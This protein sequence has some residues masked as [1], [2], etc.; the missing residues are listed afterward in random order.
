MTFEK[1]KIQTLSIIEDCEIIFW[2]K[3][4]VFNPGVELRGSRVSG[5]A[6]IL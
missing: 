6:L 5:Y 1:N 3:S 2:T 4:F